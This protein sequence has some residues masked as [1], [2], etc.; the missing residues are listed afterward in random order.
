MGLRVG[1]AAGLVACTWTS[2]VRSSLFIIVW[3]RVTEVIVNAN[4]LA[5]KFVLILG[6]GALAS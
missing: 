4:F 5:G 3:L 2:G 1:E 6:L